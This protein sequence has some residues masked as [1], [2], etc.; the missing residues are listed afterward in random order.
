M[1]AAFDPLLSGLWPY[2]LGLH[3][4]MTFVFALPG[5]RGGLFHS[6]AALVPFWAALGVLGLDDVIGWLARLRRWNVKQA[7]AFFGM[8]LLAWAVFLS[9][10]VFSGKSAEWARAGAVLRRARPA[11]GRDCRQQRPAR[12]VLLPPRARRGAAQRRRRSACSTWRRATG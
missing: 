7:R 1:A 8:A 3:L 11:A 9:L 12:A 6:A 5:P 4:L 2:A 10:W